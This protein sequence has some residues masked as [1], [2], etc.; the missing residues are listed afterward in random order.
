M[1]NTDTKAIK[2]EKKSKLIITQIIFLYL[3][4]DLIKVVEIG[5]IEK[6][7]PTDKKLI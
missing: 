2:I 4:F 1:L 5:L 3:L 7:N 6:I